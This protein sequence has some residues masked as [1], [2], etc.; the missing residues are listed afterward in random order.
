MNKTMLI[1]GLL[2]VV[3]S[4]SVRAEEKA[5]ACGDPRRIAALYHD[6]VYAGD[7]ADAERKLVSAL[8]PVVKCLAKDGLLE[9]PSGLPG[10]FRLVI[11]VL[12][13]L[14]R[15]TIFVSTPDSI[16]RQVE[17]WKVAAR[18]QETGGGAQ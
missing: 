10:R 16:H 3:M 18:A 11:E 5:D 15:E 8:F 9:T 2:L 1:S 14:R 13:A 7:R 17:V 4:G 6:A 12:A